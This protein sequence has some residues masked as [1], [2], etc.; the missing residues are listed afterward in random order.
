MIAWRLQEHAGPLRAALVEQQQQRTRAVAAADAA[1]E[2]IEV[3]I[4]IHVDEVRA[5]VRRG[6]R[7]R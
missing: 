4:A 2:G 6:G 5:R 3:P 7:A 1:D